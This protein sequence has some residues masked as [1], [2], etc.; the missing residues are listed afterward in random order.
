[1][2]L[3]VLTTILL[4]C[5][6]ATAFASDFNP[7][8]W[9]DSPGSTYQKWSFSTSDT[10]PIADDYNNPYGIPTVTNTINGNWNNQ[11]FGHQGIW[12]AQTINIS[13]PND[14]TTLNNTK[15]RV[16]MIWDVPSTSPVDMSLYVHDYLCTVP[17]VKADIV[18]DYTVLEGAVWRYTTFEATTMPFNSFPVLYYQA[19]IIHNA[20]I[21]PVY[22]DEI[23]IDTII[24]PEPL[25]LLLLAAGGTLLTTRRHR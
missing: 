18:D 14:T 17:A 15:Y 9:R 25:S 12:N 6:V 10:S 24:I 21:V 22:V 1:M 23:I 4:L 13:V 2:K 20:Q 11:I 3:S 7:P 19:Q 16:Q 8:A 5:L